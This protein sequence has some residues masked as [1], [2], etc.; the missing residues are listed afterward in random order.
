MKMHRRL[1]STTANKPIHVFWFEDFILKRHTRMKITNLAGLSNTP[2]HKNR[3]NPIASRKNLN[4][5]LKR[6]ELIDQ[7]QFPE[8][9]KYTQPKALERL[10]NYVLDLRNFGLTSNGNKAGRLRTTI[11]LSDVTKK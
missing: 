3:F 5:H 4:I 6:P 10:I 8:H 7:V 11:D 2:L 9:L 1:A